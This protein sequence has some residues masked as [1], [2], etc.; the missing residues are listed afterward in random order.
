VVVQGCNPALGREGQKLKAS[1]LL[2]R[3]KINLEYRTLSLINKN[4]TAK[5]KIRPPPTFC[6][7][8]II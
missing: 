1:W 2:R 8:H 6:Y 5:E 7:T 4:P 3:F